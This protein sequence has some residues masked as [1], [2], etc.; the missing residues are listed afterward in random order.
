MKQTRRVSRAS[1]KTAPV[2]TVDLISKARNC[3][4]FLNL[5]LKHVQVPAAQK[6]PAAEAS[7]TTEARF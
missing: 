1:S 5:S 3:H 4:N 7:E 6:P 2:K